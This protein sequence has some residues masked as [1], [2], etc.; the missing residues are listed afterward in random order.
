MAS[1]SV[2]TLVCFHDDVVSDLAFNKYGV[3]I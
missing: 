1:M 2:T 3:Y